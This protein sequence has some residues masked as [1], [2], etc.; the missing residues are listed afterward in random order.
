MAKKKEAAPKKPAR[1]RWLGRT[2]PTVLIDGYA[3]KLK[4]FLKAMEDGMIDDDEVA[5][6]EKVVVEMMKEVEPQ[7]E[8]ELH[9]AMTRLLC[10]LTAYNIMQTL[11]SLQAGRP[12]TV[13]RG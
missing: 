2:T 13:F 7:L 11:H 6:Q 4:S 9:A 12:Q 8:N 1:T 10:E 3:K 5:E